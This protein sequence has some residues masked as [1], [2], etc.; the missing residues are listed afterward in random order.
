MPVDRCATRQSGVRLSEQSG[1]L[2]RVA[3]L[4]LVAIGQEGPGDQEQ[5]GDDDHQQLT[6]P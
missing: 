5:S 1:T 3:A 6:F 2:R 4:G